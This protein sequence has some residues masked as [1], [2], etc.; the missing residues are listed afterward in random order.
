MKP[1]MERR[2]FNNFEFREDEET[3]TIAGYASVFNEEEDFGYFR[4]VIERGA[5]ARAIKEKHDV[6]SLFNHDSN[7]VLGRSSSGTLTLREDEKGLYTETIPPNTSHGRDVV[8]L[9]RRG[10]ISKM[11]FA[12]VP[13]SVEWRKDKEDETELRVIKDVDLYDISVVTRPAYEGTSVGLR[14]ADKESVKKVFEQ[15]AIELGKPKSVYLR[16]LEL[17]ELELFL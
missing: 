10:D 17:L 14:N 16:E 4:E 3:P 6:V 1:K 7:I 12:F 15:R 11:S 5:F 8:E 9:M 2:F 13:T